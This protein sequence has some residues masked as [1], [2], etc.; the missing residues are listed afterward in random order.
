MSPSRPRGH[1]SV[2]APLLSSEATRDGG[3]LGAVG[4]SGSDVA[5]VASGRL[6]VA[7]GRLSTGD[8]RDCGGVLGEWGGVLGAEAVAVGQTDGGP[9]AMATGGE[10]VPTAESVAGGWRGWVLVLAA[11]RRDVYSASSASPQS[12]RTP[13][14]I[15]PTLPPLSLSK[16]S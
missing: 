5:A 16:E 2:T 7:V 9:L 1:P 13:S 3:T 10:P 6:S 12:L 14:K 15:V 11:G 4:K 8:C